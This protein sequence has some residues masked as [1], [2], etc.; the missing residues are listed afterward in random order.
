MKDDSSLEK[1]KNSVQHIKKILDE[2]QH[3]EINNSLVELGMI[4]FI[5]KKNGTITIELKIPF[6][7]VPIKQLL[8][9]AIK[10][11]LQ[12]LPTTVVCSEMD[13]EEKQKFFTLSK[14][15]WAL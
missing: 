13:E 2:V 3:P 11:K 1:D 4:G 14:A 8:I 12:P 10:N 6:L 5:E 15:N 9:D 7:E